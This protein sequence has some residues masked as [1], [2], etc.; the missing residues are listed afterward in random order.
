MDELGLR[1]RAALGEQKAICDIFME[2]CMN[3]AAQIAV[4]NAQIAERKAKDEEKA[5][6][7]DYG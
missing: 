6:E 3:L 1:L 4:L 7:P 5:S 2:R